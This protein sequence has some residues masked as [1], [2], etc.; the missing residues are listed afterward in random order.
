MAKERGAPKQRPSVKAS[1]AAFDLASL[2]LQQDNDNYYFKDRKKGNLLTELI[3]HDIVPVPK[4]QSSNLASTD[5][6][7]S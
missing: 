4:R 1:P 6:R 3:D 2:M 7:A 5:I